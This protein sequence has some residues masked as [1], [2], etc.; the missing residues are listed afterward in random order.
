MALVHLGDL[1]LSGLHVGRDGDVV[2]LPDVVQTVEG[3]RAHCCGRVAAVGD[4]R[5][6]FDCGGEVVADA[7]DVFC[8]DANLTI[9]LML[10]L[11]AVLFATRLK[12]HLR[13]LHDALPGL[14]DFWRGWTFEWR[15]VPQGVFESG[16]LVIVVAH[17][18]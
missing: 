4:G 14:L 10:S 6:V 2:V 16:F 17:G 18:V 8:C 1:G 3:V 5:R 12:M 9:C 15:F 13:T 7:D 11:V